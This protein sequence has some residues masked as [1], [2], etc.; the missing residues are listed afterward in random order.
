M[1]LNDRSTTSLLADLP[2][3]EQANAPS[4][5]LAPPARTKHRALRRVGWGVAGSL[6]LMT[7]AYAFWPKPEMTEAAA[8]VKF[9]PARAQGYLT[10]I[11]RIGSRVSGSKGMA[12]QQRVIIDH[13]TRLGAKIGYQTFDIAHPVT[14]MPVRMMNIIVSWH[15]ES[16]ERILLACH[17]DTRP[18]PDRDRN[19]PRGIFLGANDGASGVAFF[20][21]L[22]NQMRHLKPTHGVDF[23]FFDGEEMIYGDRGKYFLGSEHFA[24]R[25]RDNPPPH[26]YRA[27]VVVDMIGDKNLDLYIEKNS[28]N[29]A[30]D[31]TLS[32]WATAR[33]LGVTEFK[34]EVKHEVQD[35]HLPLNE[36]A[37]IPTCDIIDFD[38]PYWHTMQDVPARCSGTSLEKVARVL[39]AWLET[40]QE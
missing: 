25:Y 20:M 3:Q 30:K 1:S 27:G 36:I 39:T 22:G 15:P 35:D 2:T 11:C 24:K 26:R 12:E 29:Y 38:Y 34:Q 19:N 31:V 16:K 5:I 10:K 6:F 21:E 13:F 8:A 23:V 4:E 7:A 18:Y 37:K 33:K 32:I 14:G 17:Y 9:D 40:P 28:L